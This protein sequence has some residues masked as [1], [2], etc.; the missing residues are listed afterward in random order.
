MAEALALWL[1]QGNEVAK[2][3]AGETI[4][5][6]S[7]ATSFDCREQN[8]VSNAKLSQHGLANAVDVLSFAF[9]GGKEFGLTDSTASIQLRASLHDLACKTFSTV[10][11]PGS[12]GYHED[13][14]HLDLAGRRG[15]YR[16]CQWNVRSQ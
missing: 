6:V 1:R 2:R 15:G 11:G 16:I 7:I 9:K 13:H 8:G 12:D 5:G 4:T 10:L 14:I 3:D